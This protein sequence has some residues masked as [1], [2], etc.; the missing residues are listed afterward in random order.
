ML[1]RVLDYDVLI[2]VSFV[3]SFRSFLILIGSVDRLA[4]LARRLVGNSELV[5]MV[6]SRLIGSCYM[7]ISRVSCQSVRELFVAQ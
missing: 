6:L 1:I 2:D 4:K 5:L 3:V 7:N